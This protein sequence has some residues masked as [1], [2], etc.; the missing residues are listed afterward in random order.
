M[1][2]QVL[3]QPTSEGGCGVE[4]VE[5]LGHTEQDLDD[6]GRHLGLDLSRCRYRLLP[7]RGDAALAEVSEE[8]DFWLTASYMSRLAPRATRSAY[9][10]WFP[11]PFDH[12]LARRRKTLVRLVG[13]SP[14]GAPALTFGA[15]GYPPEG[16][17]RRRW[18][19]TSGD[20]VLAVPPGSNRRLRADLGRPGAPGPTTLRVEDISG[21]VLHSIPVE[22]R[23]RRHSLA[24]GHSARGRAGRARAEASST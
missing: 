24:L 8:Y 11:T 22:S 16:G 14:R 2:A 9:L 20:G 10:C 18:V 21:R 3:S 1:V 6:L 17:R 13:P 7:D 19:W 4:Q 15:G 12:D 23:F 5:L